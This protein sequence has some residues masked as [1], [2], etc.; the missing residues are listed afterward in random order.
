M[1]IYFLI[2]IP[3]I[4]DISWGNTMI[5]LIFLFK[6]PRT[7]W[8]SSAVSLRLLPP[9]GLSLLLQYFRSNEARRSVHIFGV[10]WILN[11]DCFFLKNFP[12]WFKWLIYEM[13][14][15]RFSFFSY[16]FLTTNNT[17][18]LSLDDNMATPHTSYKLF[19]TTERT[20]KL[21]KH[22]L[23]VYC[24]QWPMKVFMWFRAFAKYRLIL[25]MDGIQ[26]LAMNH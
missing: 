1:L 9:S 20:R 19:R 12:S 3:I 11:I 8:R 23:H 14:D 26:H 22:N 13:N 5:C 24:E 16:I 18:F 10:L 2:T 17:L 15:S 21:P 25:H 6:Y 7:R 4:V